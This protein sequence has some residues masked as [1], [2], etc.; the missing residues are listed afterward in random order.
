MGL[1]D[2]IFGNK[3]QQSKPTEIKQHSELYDI[4]FDWCNQY[5]L[6]LNDFENDFYP[7]I[8]KCYNEDERTQLTDEGIVNLKLFALIIYLTYHKPD[9]NYIDKV[10]Y[11]IL[12]K[13]NGS[14]Y[15]KEEIK[16][17]DRRIFDSV[18]EIKAIVETSSII[19]ELEG[20][21]LNIDTN[22]SY[23]SSVIS[24]IG[25][26]KYEEG[27][28]FPRVFEF[29]KSIK[30]DKKP[31]LLMGIYTY[32]G[33]SYTKEK[34]S[35]Y[36]DE[37]KKEC[38]VAIDEY[39]QN[40]AH[41][42][43]LD[44]ELYYDFI[45]EENIRENSKKWEDTPYA[46]RRFLKPEDLEETQKFLNKYQENGKSFIFHCIY[47]YR[48]EYISEPNFYKKIIAFFIKRIAFDREWFEY[49][50]SIDEKR[51]KFFVS[52]IYTELLSEFL[53]EIKYTDELRSLYEKVLYESVGYYDDSPCKKG[54]KLLKKICENTIEDK[55]LRDFLSLKY[56]DYFGYI[57]KHPSMS[58]FVID[59]KFNSIK[60][61]IDDINIL[62]PISLKNVKKIYEDGTIIKINVNIDNTD[63]EISVGDFNALLEK[64]LTG[65]RFTFIPIQASKRADE[66][67]I[68]CSFAFL[69]KKQFEYLTEVYIPE[70]FKEINTLHLYG[71]LNY[72]I[73]S[74]L[75]FEEVKQKK[76]I[77]KN[78]K[79]N[80]FETDQNW[81]WFKQKYIDLLPNKKEWYKI[82]D[83]ILDVKGS[84]TPNKTWAK[85]IQKAIEKHNTQ[86]YFKE[87]NTLISSSI[88]EDFWF[89]GENRKFMKAF[90]WTCQFFPTE[91]SLLV[92]KK[93]IEGAYTKI[94]GV[95]PRCAA[96]GNLGLT[97]LA[98]INSTESFGILQ[99]LRNK[100]NI[101]GL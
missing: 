37:V 38:L 78:T 59:D 90:I 57:T 73:D 96:I 88:K 25:D 12:D 61:A 51:D 75:T 74:D 92:L 20:V 26:L 65:F 10:L 17:Y 83:I 89:F 49:I 5:N 16:R 30:S 14:Y 76:L 54:I 46:K 2:K 24:T 68:L 55:K 100:Q 34:V 21:V 28:V 22:F 33:Y 56:S 48:E 70:N 63:C 81:S 8:E 69:N 58:N 52:E 53:P 80:S 84:K 91:D 72:Y 98:E 71:Y 44:F 35:K 31:Y 19:L 23:L 18:P 36:Q 79:D 13:E 93:I 27:E 86:K 45:E 60:K 67:V 47:H 99:L 3:T 42:C 9:V 32:S 77:T 43:K 11:Y 82:M 64:K 7:K 94:R 62:T 95:G 66:D 87:L 39:N 97:T 6:R 40:E 1:F 41:E 15:I 85:S 50:L 29:L 101:N 4:L